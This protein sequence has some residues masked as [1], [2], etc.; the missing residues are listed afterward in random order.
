MRCQHVTP[1][2]SVASS[3]PVCAFP[4][5]HAH[6]AVVILQ[7][8]FEVPETFYG[9]PAWK[10]RRFLPRNPFAFPVRWCGWGCC[11]R[12]CRPTVVSQPLEAGAQARLH[13]ET[14]SQNT[15]T[16]FKILLYWFFK[17][18][19]ILPQPLPRTPPNPH[20]RSDPWPRNEL[21]YNPVQQ[22]VG[23]SRVG[24]PGWAAAGSSCSLSKGWATT[25]VDV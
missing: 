12:T 10:A 14:L 18:L 25:A 24:A 13:V 8:T 16:I 15:K 3:H 21:V 23:W 11:Y 4:H 5:V 19:L 20:P 2:G 7:S 22:V 9:E 6:T 1:L 17:L